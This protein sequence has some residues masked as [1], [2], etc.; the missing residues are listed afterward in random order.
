MVLAE[1][2]TDQW[3]RIESPEIKSHV[4]GKLIYEKG[5]KYT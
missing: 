2:Q 5:E 4:Y 1:K 3:A